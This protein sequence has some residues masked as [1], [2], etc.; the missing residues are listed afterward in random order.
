MD[1]L[2]FIYAQTFEKYFEKCFVALRHHFPTR[3]NMHVYFSLTH[4][5]ER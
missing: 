1:V 4:L 3:D 2:P 5:T